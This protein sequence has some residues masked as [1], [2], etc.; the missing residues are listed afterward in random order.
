[1]GVGNNVLEMEL[2]N[3]KNRVT[4]LNVKC[5]NLSCNFFFFKFWFV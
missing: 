5:R 3:H 4:L 1:M 2:H